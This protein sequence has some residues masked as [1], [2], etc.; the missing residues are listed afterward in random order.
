MACGWRSDGDNLEDT[1]CG[2]R[3]RDVACYLGVV[4]EPMRR[5]GTMGQPSCRSCYLE[6]LTPAQHAAVLSEPPDLAVSIYYCPEHQKIEDELL[7]KLEGFMTPGN[8]RRND[9][10]EMFGNP[11]SYYS[12]GG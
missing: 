4:R 12:Y 3:R 6:S 11:S 7:K 10:K 9:I 5:S 1:K 8:F 2:A